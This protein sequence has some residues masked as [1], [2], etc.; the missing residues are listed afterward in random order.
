MLLFSEENEY[1]S[2]TNFYFKTEKKKT[3]GRSENTIIVVIFAIIF[4]RIFKNVKNG[5]WF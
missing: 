4:R 2:Y 1:F 3:K 5:A